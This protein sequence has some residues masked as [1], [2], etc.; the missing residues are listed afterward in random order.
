MSSSRTSSAA[1]AVNST[2]RRGPRVSGERL[3]VQLQQVA[4]G[5]LGLRL[6]VDG[7]AVRLMR[8]VRYAP[9]VLHARVDDHRGAVGRRGCGG[10]TLLELVLGIRLTRVIARGDRHVHVCMDLRDEKVRTVG[11][12]G[13]QSAAVEGRGAAHT[14]ILR[15][16]SAEHQWPAHAV[17][18]G[19]D[20]A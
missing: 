10:E 8:H 13:Y 2:P 9:A 11:L 14:L 5:D 3:A 12:V 6:V 17:A 16:G 15:G 4:V 20:L 1:A 7:F 18:M 19:A